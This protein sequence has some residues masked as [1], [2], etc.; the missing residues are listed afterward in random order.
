MTGI[1]GEPSRPVEALQVAMNSS[2]D[3]LEIA[4][5][6]LAELARHCSY[7]VAVAPSVAV[8]DEIVSARSVA[9]YC[10]T[11][12]AGHGGRSWPSRQ[13]GCRACWRSQRLTS[14]TMR[15]PSNFLCPNCA[16]RSPWDCRSS[17]CPSGI[18]CVRCTACGPSC[19][20]PCRCTRSDGNRSTPGFWSHAITGRR[21]DGRRRVIR[22]SQE[23]PRPCRRRQVR[24][25]R[26]KN[27]WRP[28]RGC[29]IFP[30]M[31]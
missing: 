28:G 10:S 21:P 23:V 12:G 19:P 24:H 30:E 3:G 4:E 18:T 31:R 20:K 27:R 17:R 25:P 5:D 26:P 9:G 1:N 2:D 6:G 15:Q 8:Y 16:K 22:E 14:V 11:G 7:T 13:G 29:E